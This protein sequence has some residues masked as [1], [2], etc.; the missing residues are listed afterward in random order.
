MW[1]K[2]APCWLY[3]KELVR[4]IPCVKPSEA[5]VLLSCAHRHRR[6]A[7]P[8]PPHSIPRAHGCWRWSLEPLTKREQLQVC[9]PL[10]VC[11][12]CWSMSL[13]HISRATSIVCACVSCRLQIRHPELPVD[14]GFLSGLPKLSRQRKAQSGTRDN[15]IHGEQ[16]VGHKQSLS[17][18]I[19]GENLANVDHVNI[20]D[21]RLWA[22]G[23]WVTKACPGGY[24]AL[25]P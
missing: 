12:E 24:A 22:R 9:E 5:S 2:C 10:I 14:S 25:D 1:E 13:V 18:L 8:T 16:L 3:T 15:G 4:E 20:M 19:A 21:K 6:L 7:H 11:S 17:F 23:C